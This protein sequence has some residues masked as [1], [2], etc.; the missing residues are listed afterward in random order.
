MSFDIFN[1]FEANTKNEVEKI[2]KE[3][4]LKDADLFYLVKLSEAKIIEFPYLHACKYLEDVPENIRLSE[5]NINAITNNGVGK[6]SRE[7][8]KAVCKLF[9][10]P[11]Q[12]KRTTA[13][14]FYRCD[15]RFWHLFFFD[16][17]DGA[18]AENHWEHGSHIHYVSWLWPNLKC[19]E[20]WA[21]FCHTGKKSIGGARHIRFEK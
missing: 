19:Q 5:K 3:L 9:Q 8:Q 20:V 11:L 2:C 12:V 7:A 15:H 10:M 4:T 13:H 17:K 14:M 1:L 21:S 18:S 16:L 6:L